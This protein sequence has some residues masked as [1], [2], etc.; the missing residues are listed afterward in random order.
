MITDPAP[1]DLILQRAGRLQ[2]HQGIDRSS[3]LLTPRL[4]ITIPQM[5]GAT[6]VWGSDGWVYEPYVLLRSYLALSGLSEIIVPADVQPLIEAVYDDE[7]PIPNDLDTAL[8]KTLEQAYQAMIQKIKR[9]WY[10]ACQNL[11]LSPD[12]EDVLSAENRQLDE[13]NP[14][15]HETWRAMTRLT[16]PSVTLVCLHRQADGVTLDPDGEQPISL[17][18]QPDRELTTELAQHTVTISNYPVFKHFIAQE[19]PPGWRKH[20]LLRY[21]RAAIFTE[22]RIDL[23]DSWLVLDPELGVMTESKE[24]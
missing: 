20:P 9:D 16:R 7:N 11:I 10:K 5:Q 18:E 2:R 21:Y 13:D 22:G 1:V 12:D 19:P 8:Q 4:L 24:D 3:R 14:E 23:G 6:P 15:L 17:E